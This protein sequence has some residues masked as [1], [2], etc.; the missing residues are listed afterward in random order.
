[1]RSIEDQIVHILKRSDFSLTIEEIAK[2]LGITRQTT[3]KYL[4]YMEGKGSVKRR[5]V[6]A[7]KLYY[8]GGK[9]R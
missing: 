7:A 8:I 1:M 9:G 6:G 5:N 3:S 2:K 4:F